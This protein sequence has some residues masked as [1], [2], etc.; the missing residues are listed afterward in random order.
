VGKCSERIPFHGHNRSRQKPCVLHTHDRA[1]PSVPQ[2]AG[3]RQA[4]GRWCCRTLVAAGCNSHCLLCASILGND[5]KERLDT[6]KNMAVLMPGMWRVSEAH[7]PATAV[8]G[9][10]MTVGSAPQQH[11][12][13]PQQSSGLIFAHG[14][15][16]FRTCREV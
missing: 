2:T 13:R 6:A 7:M 5:Y 9:S 11:G 1:S 10:E 15:F 8:V 4:P 14:V 12:T 16:R 3:A